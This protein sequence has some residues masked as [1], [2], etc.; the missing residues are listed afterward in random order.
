MDHKNI[1]KLDHH[2]QQHLSDVIGCSIGLDQ[3]LVKPLRHKR[4]D[5]CDH[6]ACMSKRRVSNGMQPASKPHEGSLAINHEVSPQREEHDVERP[7]GLSSV[8]FIDRVTFAHGNE[9][10]KTISQWP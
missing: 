4:P 9:E 8:S 7:G 6:C 5:I 3:R 1:I 2:I 10:V